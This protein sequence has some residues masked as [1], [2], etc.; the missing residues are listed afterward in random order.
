MLQI[1]NFSLECIF[2]CRFKLEV[3]EFAYYKYHKLYFSS[4]HLQ[5]QQTLQKHLV[6]VTCRHPGNLSINYPSGEIFERIDCTLM[7]R[8]LLLHNYVFLN[9]IH[10]NVHIILHYYVSSNVLA[11]LIFVQRIFDMRHSYMTFHLNESYA[12]SS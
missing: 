5:L 2:M 9:N 11:S 12:D 4:R 7:Q 1:C 8:F 6:Q 3:D 10:Y